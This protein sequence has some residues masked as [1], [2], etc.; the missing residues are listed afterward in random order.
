MNSIQGAPMPPEAIASLADVP[1]QRLS[2]LAS[3]PSA[4]HQ[5]PSADF[6]RAL[7][8][9]ASTPGLHPPGL[10]FR[11]RPAQAERMVHPHRPRVLADPIPG[12]PRYAFFDPVY[13]WSAFGR[14]S[15]GQFPAGS[16]FGATGVMV[17]PRHLLTSSRIVGWHP[18][19]PT[20]WLVFTP[21]YSHGAAPFG[22]AY[23]TKIY[24]W[25]QL[26]YFTHDDRHDLLANDYAVVVLDHRIG[27]VTGWLGS[28]AYNPA[29]N[30]RDYWDFIGYT[31][32]FGG[33]Q[34]P[35]FQKGA[36]IDFI[37][38]PE[39]ATPPANALLMNYTAWMGQFPEYESGG[40]FF[41]WW[42]GESFPRVIGVHT[43]YNEVEPRH[44]P[45]EFKYR[46]ACGGLPMVSV[47]RQALAEFP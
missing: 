36:S 13:P 46:Y 18:N 39:G 6:L 28:I 20:D 15:T 17:G 33:G 25:R 41:G 21:S 34:E 42:S 43:V 47:I 40:P 38:T 22:T 37:A 14:V 16:H 27:E 9:H 35:V 26:E 24:A 31:S 1:G 5:P 45:P 12:D 10:G 29:W 8:G 11:S 23:A 3:P 2:H 7:P 19:A 32:D 30:L 4:L 44:G